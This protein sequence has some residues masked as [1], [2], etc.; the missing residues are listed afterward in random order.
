MPKPLK[1]LVAQ[2][3]EG[4]PPRAILIGGTSDFLAEQAFREVR[5]AIVAKQ[6]SIA[7]EQYEPGAELAAV[8]DSYR[9]MSLFGSA[10]LLIVPEVNAFVSA[11]ELAALFDKSTS[12]WK[13]AKTDRKRGTASAKLLHLLGLA[14]AD[15]EMTDRQIASA[16]GVTLDAT[17]TDMLA[18]CRATGKKAGRGEDDAA[19]LIEA[20]ARGGAPGTILLMRTGEVPKDSATVDLID[21]HGAV[22]VNDLTR[23][24]F[25]SALDVAIAGIA[26]EAHV[27]FDANAVARLRQRLGI[28]R[29][30]ADKF[31]K[32]VP[33]IRF[34]VTEAERLATLVGAGGR[35]TADIVEREIAAVEGGA[36]YEFGSLFTEGKVLEAVAKLRELVAQSKREDPKTANEIHYGKFLFPLA[37]ELRQMIGIVSYAKA[38]NIDLSRSMQYNRFKDTI[39]ERLGDYLKNAGLVRQRPHPFP[40]HKKWEAARTANEAQLFRALAELAEMEIK[41]KSGGLPVDVALESFLLARVRA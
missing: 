23:E 16:L 3:L 32:E 41:R 15:L 7:I 2:I 26:E 5:D 40:L 6:P 10:R 28:D 38:N 1:S 25:V 14:G 29:L 31:S 33:E 39:A 30:L 4:T 11:K 21:K 9:T 20:I 8:L 22:I 18:F 34:A 19:M 37:D 12:E 35:V 27:K 13:S 36:R 17:L 24:G